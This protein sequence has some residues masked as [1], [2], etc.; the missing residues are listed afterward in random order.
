MNRGTVGARPVCD[1]ISHD[2]TKQLQALSLLLPNF[3]V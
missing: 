1:R 3:D 2:A